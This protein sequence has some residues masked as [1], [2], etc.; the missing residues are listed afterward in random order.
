MVQSRK[1][2]GSEKRASWP[3]KVL[4]IYWILFAFFDFLIN[5]PDYLFA[6]NFFQYFDFIILSFALIA[7]L[8]FP[9]IKKPFSFREFRF[10]QFRL[11]Y[12]Y[13]LLLLIMGL[14]SL[15]FQ[16][17]NGNVGSL[18]GLLTKT[19]I[20]HLSV[21]FVLLAAY[22]T[23]AAIL[24]RF[25]DSSFRG[26]RFFV[27][28]A[29]G[30]VI[31]G[32]LL[33]S[34]AA[35]GSYSFGPVIM[36]LL[37]MIFPGWKEV[38]FLFRNT[39]LKK[40]DTTN[41]LNPFSLVL[42][43]SALVIT[44]INFISIT[45]PFPLGYDSLTLYLNLPLLM[46]ESTE[47]VRGQMPYYWSL[48]MGL[49]YVIFD[50]NPV[51]QYLGVIG[52]LLTMFLII[53]W[54]RKFLSLNWAVFSGV[55]FYLIPLVIWQSSIEIK[56]DLGMLF[57]CLLAVLIIL[58]YYG[59]K[60]QD[61]GKE[62]LRS[63]GGLKDEIILWG[64]SGIF[65]GFA[66]GIKFTAVMGAIGL[67]GVLFYYRSG[68]L[69]ALSWSIA[70]ISFLFLGGFYRFAGLNISVNEKWF[71]SFGL[72]IVA[73]VIFFLAIKNKEQFFHLK[74]PFGIFIF[75]ILL[76]L[77]PWSGKNL[78]EHGE[79]SLSNLI[80]G[81]DPAPEWFSHLELKQNYLT[82][83]VPIFIDQNYVD[84][85]PEFS[86]K[87]VN[88][89]QVT[90]IHQQSSRYEEIGRYLGYEGG[91]MRFLSLPYDISMK[92]NVDLLSTD[93]GVL[94]ILFIPLLLLAGF[95]RNFKRWLPSFIF[96]LGW[97]S[98]SIWSVYN[99][100]NSKV[101]SE[102]VNQL[103]VEDNTSLIPI[104]SAFKQLHI[105][106]LYPLLILGSLLSPIYGF[107][108]SGGDAVSLLIVFSSVILLYFMF[109]NFLTTLDFYTKGWALFLVLYFV[110]WIALS[111]GIP[112]Y[113]IIGMTFSLIFLARTFFNH[114]ASIYNNIGAVKYLS[115]IVVL[116]WLILLVCLRLSPLSGG[117]TPQPE[118]IDYEPIIIPSSVEYASGIIDADEY[119][120]RIF[121][122]EIKRIKN[123]LN[124][125]HSAVVLNVATM[126]RFFIEKDDIRVID[127]NQLD[128]FAKVWENSRQSKVVTAN[129]LKNLGLDYILLDL[130][131]HTLD[132][133]PDGSLRRKVEEFVEF[134]HNNPHIE[135]IATD[136]LVEHPRGD[137]Q[138]EYQGRT[139]LVR[140]DI[141]GTQII[142][143]GKLALFRLK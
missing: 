10:N 71:L 82:D 134:L 7:G 42:I 40:L 98:L 139:I 23:G 127:D 79:F 49:G 130:N 69:L 31:K 70:A 53:N 6:L 93:P 100:D 43:F 72:L 132:M 20:I 105:L 138:M 4:A 14:F 94:F 22:S 73:V 37:L 2:L 47:L 111:S 96:F 131:V 27:S 32:L 12:F 142:E 136:R 89:E 30:M 56:T 92:R 24:S 64:L 41:A 126:M 77:L 21:V 123:H 109:K 63:T 18:Y 120:I 1:V 8:V 110:I 117:K 122:R 78:L 66:M 116:F 16:A 50:S 121:N 15:F 124:Q 11:I 104:I 84:V 67:I 125:D 68:K 101:L 29:I 143:R 75:S 129:R 46:S 61:G 76:M 26:I 45:T 106:F 39:I 36:L 107:L 81:K 38:I 17:K 19:I 74:K 54:S 48:I 115:I 128:L 88:F 5:S 80:E 95:N 90:D 59:L 83:P 62:E 114:K 33:F 65:I 25:T 52:G 28:L 137:R 99:P 102:V 55:F 140:N 34:L 85:R 135:L 3:I 108:I 113:G 118:I 51:V 97:I 9:F 87:L 58:G 44:A 35:I 60:F 91:A 57:F 133:T 119:F 141:F 103:S 13:P 112:W 86:V